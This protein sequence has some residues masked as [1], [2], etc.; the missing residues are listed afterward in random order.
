MNLNTIK[1]FGEAIAHGDK[2]IYQTVPRLL[3][4][5]L[6]MG[7]NHKD[8]ADHK[9]TKKATAYLIRHTKEAPAYKVRLHLAKYRQLLMLPIE[10]VHCFP[11]DC[12][13]DRTPKPYC[14]VSSPGPHH[15]SH[16]GISETGTLAICVCCPCQNSYFS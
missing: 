3:T 10:V 15:Q 14:L 7:E 4:L 8:S 12:F 2:Y 11:A 16:Q 6:D 13:S 9:P 1:C 5:W